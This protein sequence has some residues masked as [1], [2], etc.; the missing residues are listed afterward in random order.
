MDNLHQLVNLGTLFLK[1][2]SDYIFSHVLPIS[3]TN[4]DLIFKTRGVNLM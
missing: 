1:V 3:S 2:E 4:F